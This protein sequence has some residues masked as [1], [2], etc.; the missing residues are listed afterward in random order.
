MEN[1]IAVSKSTLLALNEETLK[2][3]ES[4]PAKNLPE[5]W[6][7]ETVSFRRIKAEG[8]ESGEKIVK[9]ILSVKLDLITKLFSCDFDADHFEFFNRYFI[10][11]YDYLST[12]DMDLFID[13]M[14]NKKIYGKL[15]MQMLI[16][17]L[18]EYEQ[19]RIEFAE[20]SMKEQ[21]ESIKN[22]TVELDP[23]ILAAWKDKIQPIPVKTDHEKMREAQERY[24]KENAKAGKYDK[25]TKKV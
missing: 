9:A 16:N 7:K 19:K 8:K 22:Q 10:S 5:L 3:I 6:K 1:K 23:K 24:I 14:L 20:T 11:H 15:N 25:K 12:D 21:N 17:Y 2:I 13:F 18:S 4:E